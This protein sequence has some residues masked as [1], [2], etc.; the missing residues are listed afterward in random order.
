MSEI[1]KNM[2][3][4]VGFNFEIRR[5]PTVN[6]FVQ[7]ITLPGATLGVVE[8]PNPFR[9]I[10]VFGDKIDYSE[11]EVV[12]KIDED[13]ANYL[14]IFDWITALGFPDRFEQFKQLS[15]RPRFSDERFYSDATLTILSSG[16]NPNIQVYITDLFP[17]T[18]SPI[19]MDARETDITY[20]EATATF[21]FQ[22]YTFKTQN[23]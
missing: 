15:D 22:N 5:L 21:R 14:E 20:I 18:L 6:F 10:P 12:F 23:V 19:T 13:M 8:Q 11:L 2:L 3:S 1:N 9:N 4:P 7:S 16:M 17:T